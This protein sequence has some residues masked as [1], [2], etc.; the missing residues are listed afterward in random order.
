MEPVNGFTSIGATTFLAPIP[1]VL[2]GCAADGGWQQGGKTVPNLLTVAWAGICCSK[3]PM[4][5]I[6]VRPERYSHELIE[7]TGEFTVNLVGK[8]LCHA[9]DF[10][11]VKSGKYVNKFQELGLTPVAAPPLSVA[12]ALA[13]APVTLCCEVRQTLRLGSHDLFLAEIM[14]V[15]VRREFILP[16]GSIDEQAMELVAYAH[17]KYRILG[18]ELGFFGYSVAGPEALKRRMPAE[19]KPAKPQAKRKSR[20]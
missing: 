10:C 1:S 11:G 20:K 8:T 12:P 17:G 13:E 19:K 2:I 14:D 15:R 9:M 6:A 16:D 4:V 18:R 3:P 5:S 7:K